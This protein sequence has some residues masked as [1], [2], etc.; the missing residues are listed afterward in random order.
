[1]TA[2]TCGD[3]SYQ[4]NTTDDLIA[5]LDQQNQGTYNILCEIHGISRTLDV[6]CPIDGSAMQRCV[7]LL[8][9]K[10]WIEHVDELKKQAFEN[11]DAYDLAHKKWLEMHQS[12]N[13][14]L[15][16]LDRLPDMVYTAFKKSVPNRWVDTFNRLYHLD[17]C[18]QYL[19]HVLC[20]LLLLVLI[21]LFFEVPYPFLIVGIYL[22]LEMIGMGIK[23]SFHF[24]SALS[25]FEQKTIDE[26][27]AQ[28]LRPQDF[29][30]ECIDSDL[31]DGVALGI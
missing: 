13:T 3:H 20:S 27:F 30:V 2:E 23:Q 6:E 26:T 19:K 11:I 4:L 10:L 1:M 7:V 17:A 31:V 9:E 28:L 8:R 21:L 16:D 22:A 18:L 24:V 29:G 12:D 25:T 14:C 5:L 15:H